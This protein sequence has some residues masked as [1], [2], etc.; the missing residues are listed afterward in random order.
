MYK[1]RSGHENENILKANK[2]SES[3]HTIYLIINKYVY[4][5]VYIYMYLY[6]D[7]HLSRYIMMHHDT[8]VNHAMHVNLDCG[9][10]LV[11]LRARN[12]NEPGPSP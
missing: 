3:S 4:T 2:C 9:A 8:I 6:S 11:D 1:N 5:C 10:Y 12:I 7:N